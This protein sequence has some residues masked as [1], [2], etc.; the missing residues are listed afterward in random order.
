[1]RAEIARERRVRA[2]HRSIP[3]PDADAAEFRI[4]GE[5]LQVVR[6]PGAARLQKSDDAEDE[7][8]AR[9]EIEQPLVVLDRGAGLHDDR[10]RDPERHRDLLELL[11]QH[12]PI[13]RRV[14]LR[15]PR[16]AAGFRR[17][18]EMRVRIDRRGRGRVG[19]CAPRDRR[20]ERCGEE[21]PGRVTPAPRGSLSRARPVSRRSIPLL[22]KAESLVIE[23]EDVE[24]RR[25]EVIDRRNMFSTAL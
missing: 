15:R 9:G 22:V 16:D 3:A 4:R 19:G 25:V 7:R 10:A 24:D 1:M 6:K 8:L 5:P 2:L 21:F 18:V 23:A 13:K 20:G 12:R 14:V 17:V 11:R